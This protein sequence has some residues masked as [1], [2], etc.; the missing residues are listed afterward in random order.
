MR[1]RD[2]GAV[3]AARARRLRADVSRHVRPAALQ[4]ARAEPAVARRALVA[5]AARRRARATA[6]ARSPARRAAASARSRRRRGPTPFDTIRPE[7]RRAT[8][9]AQ[10][11]STSLR[12]TTTPEALARGRERFDIYCSPCHSIAGDGDGMVARR[13]FPHPPSFH[14]DR[15]RKRRDAHF[16]AVITDGYGA[17]HSYA[18][19][20]RARRPARDHRLHPRAAADASTRPVASLEDQDRER[21]LLPPRPR[22]AP[23][24]PR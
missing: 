23:G 4:A 7:L 12:A 2:A 9:A 24:A 10:A 15:L 6:R 21:L 5:H 11:S 22:C 19:R 1:A 17:M 13:G 16:Y 8:A 14:I 3:R 20:V 18:T